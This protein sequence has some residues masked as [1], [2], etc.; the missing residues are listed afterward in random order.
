ML[1]MLSLGTSNGTR[2][3]AVVMLL[4]ICFSEFIIE[5]PWS[6]LVNFP[7]RSQNVL[8]FLTDFEQSVVYVGH[9]PPIGGS[10]HDA[11]D[12]LLSLASRHSSPASDDR[13]K[14][15]HKYLWHCADYDHMS[16]CLSV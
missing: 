4:K 10:D 15:N 9:Q 2:L 14:Q 3:H 11:V 7:T 6:Q 12:I 16:E 5:H 1:I 13:V 8:D